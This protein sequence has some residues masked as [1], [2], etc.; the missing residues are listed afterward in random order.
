MLAAE[1]EW[2]NRQPEMRYR[3]LGRTG[4]LISEIVC[5]G[6]PISPTNNPHVSGVISQMA[7]EKQVRENLP[8]AR[9]QGHL[10]YTGWNTL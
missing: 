8:V 7:D 1:A 3:K 6:D 5:G 10:P 9:A 2:R 4:F